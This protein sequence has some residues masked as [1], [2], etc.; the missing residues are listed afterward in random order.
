MRRKAWRLRAGRG[1]DS[2]LLWIFG[3]PRSGSTWLLQ[4]LAEH[5]AVVPINEPVIGNYLGPFLS[6]LPGWNASGLDTSNFTLRR[7]QRE[8]SDSFFA[9]E[10]SDVW[11][12]GLGDLMRQRFLAHAVRHPAK[13][14][15]SRTVIAIKEPNGSQSADVLMAALPK[16]RLLFLLRDGRDVVD[17]ELAGNLTGA[18]ISKEFPGAHG[19]TDERRLEFVTQSAHKWLWRTEVVEEAYRSHTGPKHL[20]RY[21]DLRAE[22]EVH[23]R[24]L[25]DW[26]GLEVEDTDL[27]AWI[28]RYAFERIS[29]GERGPGAFFRAANPGEWR[30]NLTAEEHEAVETVIGPKL[31]ELGYES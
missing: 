23:L 14:P 20:L 25:F 3:S 10:F 9:A 1:F 17:S 6:D 28:E 26:A 19:I 21:E 7:V 5:D 8:K 27:R 4:L 29:E 24:A 2:R 22:P 16:S 15:L 30:K 11:G 13:A 12:P 18:W 31:K